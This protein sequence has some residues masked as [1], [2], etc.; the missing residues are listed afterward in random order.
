MNISYK[1]SHYSHLS[2][3]EQGEISVYL[4]LR[5]EPAEIARLLDSYHSI[6]CRKIKHGVVYHVQDKNEKQTY[7]LDK[8]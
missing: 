5:R 3:F 6:I 1:K 2:A 7:F 8:S 4:K